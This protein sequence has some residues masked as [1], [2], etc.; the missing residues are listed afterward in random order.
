MQTKYPNNMYYRFQG[1]IVLIWG[2]QHVS[3]GARGLDSVEMLNH[4][5]LVKHRRAGFC[6]N[7]D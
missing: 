1:R 4:N 6:D 3:R 2:E 5:H 7:L